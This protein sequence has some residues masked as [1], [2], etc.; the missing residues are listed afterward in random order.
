MTVFDLSNVDLKVNN[1]ALTFVKAL[2]DNGFMP[3]YLYIPNA[4]E[5][6]FKTFKIIRNRQSFQR[7]LTENSGIYYNPMPYEKNIFQLKNWKVVLTIHGLRHLDARPTPIDLI[8]S[9]SLRQLS[10]LTLRMTMGFWYRNQM[11]SKYKAIVS[12]DCKELLIHTV[13]ETSASLIKKDLQI[14]NEQIAVL[15]PPP[16]Y[17]KDSDSTF[18]TNSDYYVILNA[19]RW[20]KNFLRVYWA[21]YLNNRHSRVK[22]KIFYTGKVSFLLRFL[23]R[24]YGKGLG[25]LSSTQLNKVVEASAG[26]LYPSL[27]EGWGYPPLMA[28]QLNTPVFASALPVLIE[29]YANSLRYFDPKS[30]SDIRRALN[31]NHSIHRQNEIDRIVSEQRRS[32]KYF[33]EHILT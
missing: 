9:K 19:D 28:L 22:R 24:R 31:C 26:L 21:V 14:D 6:N 29:V 10:A 17:I 4:D 25:Y 15:Y 3:D 18:G 11:R 7:T 1:G 8:A 33:Q 2:L 30:I 5:H 32:L 12:L 27:S 20:V 23:T 16:E 13:S